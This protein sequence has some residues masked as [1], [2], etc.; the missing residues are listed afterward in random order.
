MGALA[1]IV[2]DAGESLRRVNRR[3]ASAALLRVMRKESNFNLGHD[4]SE[5]VTPAASLRTR[6]L[7]G[8]PKP[9]AFNTLAPQSTRAARLFV[10]YPFLTA[11]LLPSV[12]THYLLTSSWL[13]LPASVLGHFGGEARSRVVL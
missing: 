2:M 7:G 8:Y 4:P 13:L 9:L 6:V 3:D 11:P 12:S 1:V 5:R 10:I